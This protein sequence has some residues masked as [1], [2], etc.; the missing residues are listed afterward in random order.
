MPGL[1]PGIHDF[2]QSKSEKRGWPGRQVYA[3][4]LKL[5]AGPAMTHY[6]AEAMLEAPAM[7]SIDS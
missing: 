5:A 7:R 3:A 4:C 1:V 6:C 2:I